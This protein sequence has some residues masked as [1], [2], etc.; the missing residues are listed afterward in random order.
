VSRGEQIKTE[1]RRRNSAALQGDRTRLALNMDQLD[2]ANFEH[3]WVNDTGTRIYNLTQNDDYE[4]VTDRD[5]LA[6]PDSAGVGS[7][8]ATVVDA[9]KTG[10]AIRAVLLRKPKAYHDEDFALKQRAIDEQEARISKRAEA[11]SDQG[12][13]VKDGTRLS[14]EDKP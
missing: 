12:V 5:G 2:T 4:I 3:R 10:K 6:R 13:Y 1:R 14:R 8:I 11:G 7:E 9:D